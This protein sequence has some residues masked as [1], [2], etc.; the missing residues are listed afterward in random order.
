MVSHPQASPLLPHSPPPHTLIPF[1]FLPSSSG[2]FLLWLG[3]EPFQRFPLHPVPPFLWLKHLSSCFYSVFTSSL[4]T[5]S[6]ILTGALILAVSPNRY[7]NRVPKIAEQM[8]GYW[9]WKHWNELW[10][11]PFRGGILACKS[12]KRRMIATQVSASSLP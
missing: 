4:K 10:R 3:L 12:L 6:A 9:I 11:C 8:K 7:I 1:P 5:V 2:Q